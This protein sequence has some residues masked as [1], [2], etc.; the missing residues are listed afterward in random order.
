MGCQRRIAREINEADADYGLALKGNQGTALTEIQ[1]YLAAII[2]A[3]DATL[4][5]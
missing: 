2:A 4:V 5:H 3:G 1:S